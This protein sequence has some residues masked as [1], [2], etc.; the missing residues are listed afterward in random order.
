M[1]IKLLSAVAGA[2]LL[3]APT[4]LANPSPADALH[5]ASVTSGAAA[6]A[7]GRAAPV[8]KPLPAEDVQTYQKL[9]ELQSL[10][11]WQLADREISRLKS[12]LLLGHVKAQRLLS[13]AYKAKP[14]EFKDWLAAYP[15]L[16]M[17]DD[18]YELAKQK[19]IKGRAPKR[20]FLTGVGHRG[21]QGDPTWEETDVDSGA[22][23]SK[24]DR[25]KL[26]DLKSRVRR[27][28]KDDDLDGAR[29]LIAGPDSARLFSRADADQM[30]TLVAAALYAQ[31]RDE[32]ALAAAEEAA[33]RSGDKLPQAHW[34]AGLAN[35]R[36]G[37]FEEAR[38]H[39]ETMANRKGSS[40]MISAA[41]YWAARANLVTR[42]PETVNHWLE[43]AADYSRTFYGVLAAKAL[44]RKVSYAWEARPFTDS[45]A[46][47]LTRVEGGKRALALLQLGDKVGAEEELRKL[48]PRATPALAQSM[49]ALAGTAGLPELALRLGG[50]VAAQDGRFH[51]NAAFP[52]PDWRPAG[53][54]RVDK[55]LVFAF[56]RQESGFN[57]QAKSP[58]G[59]IGLMQLMP[60]TARAM[61]G[62]GD[63]TKPSANLALG[64]KYLRKLLEEPAVGGNLFHLAAAYNSGPGNLTRWLANVKHNDDPLLFIESI[65]SR[66]TRAFVE[67]VMTNLWV[68][69][70][71]MGQPS[72][73]L[74]AIVAGGW[75][76][77][78]GMDPAALSQNR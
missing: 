61:G 66:E 55:A 37:R 25:A 10:K 31:G 1:R 16:P 78:D 44:G 48:Q 7:A 52:L 4:A 26:A 43:I 15:D 32:E 23:L 3:A 74:D 21:S 30:K 50:I 56:V 29:A 67:Q 59:A 62:S 38:P 39:F 19:G 72:P 70:D 60:A 18:V 46:D 11:Q 27:L 20:G 41:A 35:W 22:G 64:Q 8:P 5:T 71:R 51:D 69:R 24:K 49:L 76:M 33:E 45:D 28:I 47:L 9:F 13:P 77:Y 40:W 63:L 34:V 68:Y 14:Q 57:P 12:T 2:L 17:A 53:G 36:L 58:A 6:G 75:P 42:R 73:S 54:W 65:P